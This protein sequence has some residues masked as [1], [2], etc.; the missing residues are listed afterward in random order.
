MNLKERKISQMNSRHTT[1]KV[2]FN[3]GTK[4]T[5]EKGQ[6]SIN[7]GSTGYSHAEE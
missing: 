4:N 6:S 3:K 1:Y 5:M 7:D 2:I